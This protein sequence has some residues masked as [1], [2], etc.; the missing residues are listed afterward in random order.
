MQV[1][2]CLAAASVAGVHIEQAGRA[3]DGLSKYGGL[4]G[5]V[6][7]LG[8]D[9]FF[10]LSGFVISTTATGKSPGQFL[11]LRV[12]RVAPLYWLLTAAYIPFVIHSGDFTWGSLAATLTFYPEQG[13]PLLGVGWTLCFEML[14]YLVTAWTLSRPR[15]FVPLA[16]IAFA[17]CWGLREWLGGPFRFFGNPLILE[18]LAGALIAR[19]N[20]HSKRVGAAAAA[21][22][23]VGLTFIVANGTTPL[24]RL[25][26]LVNGDLALQRVAVF[27]LP[28]VCLVYAA[29]QVQFKRGLLSYL[30]DASYSL[31]LVHPIIVVALISLFPGM[32]GSLFIPLA[33]GLSIAV[34]V[35]THRWLER[36]LIA[37]FREHKG[38]SLRPAPYAKAAPGN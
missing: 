6:G 37:A 10:V 16:L 36:P 15:T 3:L 17:I 29:L 34:A 35:T 2:R 30:G 23:L 32:T 26:Y 28:A 11:W 14:F 27:G 19:A 33:F 7:T 13:L 5:D 1:L 25:T 9:V 31:Y 24:N 20:Y 12:T 18:F 8:V 22:A 38:G 21:A 4:L